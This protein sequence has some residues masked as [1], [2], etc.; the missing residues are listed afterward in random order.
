MSYALGQALQVW[1]DVLAALRRKVVSWRGAPLSDRDLHTFTEAI[2]MCALHLTDQSHRF[3]GVGSDREII[4]WAHFVCSLDVSDLGSFLSDAITALRHVSEPISY[5]EFKR[6]LSGKYPFVGAFLSP[7][8]GAFESFFECPS[9][10]GFSPCYQFLSFL[11]HLSLQDLG[12]DLEDE[13]RELEQYLHTL[14][15]PRAYIVEMNAIMREWMKDFSVSEENFFPQHGP[16]ATFETPRRA[17]SLEKYQF[18]GT[19]PMIDYVF[20]KYAGVSVG[21]Y[22]PLPL[23]VAGRTSE[24]VFVPKSMKTRRTISKEPAA[25]QYLQQGIRYALDEYLS[26]HEYLRRHVDLHNQEIN[27]RLAM[28][29][30]RNH[31]WATIDLSSASDTVTISLVKAVFR[32]TSLLPF[33]VATRSHFVQLSSKEKLRLEKFAPMGSALCFPVETL[34]FSCAVEL[35]V[36]RAQ[37]EGLGYHPTWRVYGDDIIVSDHIYEDVIRILNSLGFVVNESKSFGHSDRFRES[38]GYEGYDGVDVTPMRLSRSFQGSP[39]RWTSSHAAVFSGLVDIANQ[40]YVYDFRLLRAWV[41]Q[42]L[43]RDPASPPLFSSSVEVGVFSP[44]P[45]NFRALWRLSPRKRNWYQREEI[46][47]RRSVARVKKHSR[48]VVDDSVRLYETLRLSSKRLSDEV[49]YNDIIYVPS[50]PSVNL[51][52]CVWVPNPT[53]RLA[54][55]ALK[56]ECTD[57][58]GGVGHPV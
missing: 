34:I 28:D 7:M 24:L 33:L 14:R 2:V 58:N 16:G 32:G 5:S 51:L 46:R 39:E 27:G 12:L 50:R 55:G 10:R 42:I 49:D 54:V 45:D 20:G 37:R 52:S 36:R 8:R 1:H 57:N 18:L 40:C 3:E 35:A 13:Y 17:M 19:D 43:L 4:A 9:P 41:V 26:H 53:P 25:L 30:S 15:Y 23:K 6:S 56:S 22:S 31:K 47:I 38:C 29:G 48:P 21:T 11:T 44:M